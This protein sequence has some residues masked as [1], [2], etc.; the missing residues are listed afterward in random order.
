MAE[1]KKKYPRSTF[2]DT[3]VYLS[4]EES[5]DGIATIALG[6]DG[7]GRT[8]TIAFERPG[9]TP[10]YPLCEKLLAALKNRYGNPASTTDFQEERARNRRSEWK[11]GTESMALSCFEMPRQ[12]SY[13]ERLTITGR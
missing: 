4:N 3:V 11:T 1:L 5:H 10:A 13:A 8:L 2:L 9:N 7:S 6:A 12:P